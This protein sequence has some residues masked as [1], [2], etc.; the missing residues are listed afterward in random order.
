MVT[1]YGMSDTFGMVALGQQQNRY[2]SDETALTCSEGTA[3]E[4]D[5]EVIR[6]VEKAH[7]QA[8]DILRKHQF[9]L[10]E[11]ARYLQ[12]KETITGDEFMAIFSGGKDATSS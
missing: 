1:T 2:L 8:L 9:K 4:I 5:K 6:I 10:H 7:S 11:L 12:V 3:Q